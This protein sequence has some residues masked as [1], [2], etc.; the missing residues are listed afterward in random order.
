MRAQPIDAV[1][2]AA[3]A[4]THSVEF[5]KKKFVSITARPSHAG[6]AAAYASRSACVMRYVVFGGSAP[7]GRKTEWSAVF[8]P[9]RS[10]GPRPPLAR[11][12]ARIR[13]AKAALGA[14]A[15]PR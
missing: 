14:P 7:V 1:T 11:C 5:S 4:A 8:P 15:A 3:C 13:L 9:M 12:S 10:D 2:A 6:S